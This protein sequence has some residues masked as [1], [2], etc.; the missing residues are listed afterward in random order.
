MTPDDPFPKL[1]SERV[2]VVYDGRTG[3]IVHI[4]RVWTFSGGTSMALEPPTLAPKRA[5]QRPGKRV[6]PKR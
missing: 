5:K 2:Y 3:D 6:R 4:H 1:E